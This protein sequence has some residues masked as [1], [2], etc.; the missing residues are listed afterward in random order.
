MPPKQSQQQSAAPNPMAGLLGAG[1]PQITP[2]MAQMAMSALPKLLRLAQRVPAWTLGFSFGFLWWVAVVPLTTTAVLGSSEQATSNDAAAPSPYFPW[3][4]LSGSGPTSSASRHEADLE[5]DVD[6]SSKN[7]NKFSKKKEARKDTK[8]AVTSTKKRTFDDED[9]NV[10][11][12]HDEQ[13]HD[14]DDDRDEAET[15]RVANAQSSLIHRLRQC[16]VIR[17]QNMLHCLHQISNSLL[18]I[19]VGLLL[20]AFVSSGAAVWWHNR[21]EDIRQHERAKAIVQDIL[22]MNRKE[23]FD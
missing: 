2:E 11:D 4:L 17:G 9:N 22:Q 7:D 1:Q 3:S 20:L 21:Q 6:S 5:W 10:D 13:V 19:I 8:K 18:T 12:E 23:S 14:D 16:S 15:K